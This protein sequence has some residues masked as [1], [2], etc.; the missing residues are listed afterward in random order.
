[1]VGV[2]GAP[3]VHAIR[4]AIRAI[5]AGVAVGR[6][7][8]GVPVR[9]RGGLGVVVFRGDEVAAEG[10]SELEVGPKGSRLADNGGPAGDDVPVGFSELVIVRSGVY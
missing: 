3:V 5:C 9:L 4:G 6:G 8:V 1:M 7:A 2:V 10:A